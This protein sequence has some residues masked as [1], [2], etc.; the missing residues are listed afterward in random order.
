M[1]MSETISLG[2]TGILSIAQSKLFLSGRENDLASVLGWAAQRNIPFDEALA[3]MINVETAP[4]TP[5]PA[6]LPS[7]DDCLHSIL[8][9]IK[10]PSDPIPSPFPTFKKIFRKTMDS[11]KFVV[12]CG[13]GSW[14]VQLAL[15]VKDLR[16]GKTLSETLRRRMS[17]YLPGYYLAAVEKAE[18][19][20][21]LPEILPQLAANLRF[22]MG[23]R[24]SFKASVTYPII[25]FSTLIVIFF[26]LFTF[27][28]PKF[29]KIFCELLEET[30]LP[31]LLS[32][33]ICASNIF[34]EG[35][36]SVILFPVFLPAIIAGEIGLSRKYDMII[37][38]LIVLQVLFFFAVP[39]IYFRLALRIFMTAFNPIADFA[40]FLLMQIP[41]FGKQLRR[42]ALLEVAGA[43]AT[44]TGAGFDVVDAARWNVEAVKGR[45]MKRKIAKFASSVEGGEYWADAWED[46]KLG[47]AAHDWIIRNAAVREEPQEGFRM[48]AEWLNGEINSSNHVFVVLLEAFCIIFNACFV[49]TTLF[50]IWQVLWTVIRRAADF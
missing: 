32:T 40:S 21:M 15:T 45:W 28:I 47:S 46:M 26:G 38:L 1:K 39:L 25:Q 7:P 20:N 43:M 5:R 27:V 8:E 23:I 34:M 48:L 19:E 30:P 24:E 4:H 18:K 42:M 10:K 33:V 49:G 44:L 36:A 41:F 2:E 29:E 22:S 31:P 16:N 9:H 35:F 3:T 6:P 11:I 14:K 50:A 13:T 37:F 17:K 12:L